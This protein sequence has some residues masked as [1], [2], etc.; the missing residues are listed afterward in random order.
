MNKIIGKSMMLHQIKRVFGGD[1]ALIA[2]HATEMGATSIQIKAADGSSRYNQQLTISGYKD[3][4][5]GPLVDALRQN[6]VDAWGWQYVYGTYPEA[7]AQRAAERMSA[8][9][10][11]GWIIDIEAE[12]K[13]NNQASR[14]RRYMTTLRDLLPNATI[15]MTSYRYPSYHPEVP[16]N[17]FLP[18]VDF[19]MPQ[20]YWIGSDNPAEQLARTIE[21][22]ANL[23]GR[24]GIDPLPMIPI[25]A[26]FKEHGW[27]ATPAQVTEFLYAAKDDEKLEGVSFWEHYHAVNLELDD[28]IIDFSWPVDVLPPTEPPKDLEKAV[29]ELQVTVKAHTETL[30]VH[31]NRIGKVESRASILETDVADLSNA[32]DEHIREHGTPPE[33]PPGTI[34]VKVIDRAPAHASAGNNTSGYPIIQINAY[35]KTKDPALLFKA[36]SYAL[37]YEEKVRADG[38]TFWYKLAAITDMHGYGALYIPDK[39]VE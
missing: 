23:Y 38:G 27:Q 36:G 13:K 33:N 9:P 35:D 8:Y 3:T 5:V 25:G 17:E 10:F 7:E 1:P 18:L 28:S 19:V 34:L 6:G 12:F 24:L 22:Y 2:D 14:A 16:W 4:L 32:I 26:A 20:V 29:A 37:V 31:D 15:A 11:K 39:K 30:E 21:E